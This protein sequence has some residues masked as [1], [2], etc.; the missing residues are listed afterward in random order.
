M[1]TKANNGRF[2]KVSVCIPPVPSLLHLFKF[3]CI[4]VHLLHDIVSKSTESKYGKH[5]YEQYGRLLFLQ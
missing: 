4:Q 5:I 2:G 1:H 3:S